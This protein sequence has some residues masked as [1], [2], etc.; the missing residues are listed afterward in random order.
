MKRELYSQEIRDALVGQEVV[1]YG[2][3]QKIRSL[4]G[5]TFLDLRDR[6]GLVQVVWQEGEGLQVPEGLGR[7]SVLEVRGRRGTSACAA[8][9]IC[10]SVIPSTAW[11]FCTWRPQP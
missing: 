10:R 9:W 11:A 3:V 2:W 8:R 7:E 4:G 1:L 6:T 5:L